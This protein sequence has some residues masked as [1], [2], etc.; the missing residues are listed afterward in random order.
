MNGV[1]R[2]SAA[3]SNTLKAAVD[4]VVKVALVAG[5]GTMMMVLGLFS[6]LASPALACIVDLKR[7]E[8]PKAGA[9]DSSTTVEDTTA[10]AGT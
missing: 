1:S 6:L 7:N 9:R 10:P 8:Q 5:L 4:Y 3:L 2:K